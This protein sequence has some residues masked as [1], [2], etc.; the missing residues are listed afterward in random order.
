MRS[1][2]LTL[3]GEKQEAAK[4]RAAI[5]ECIAEI[6]RILKGM[7][8]KQTRIDKLGAHT[9]SLLAELKAMR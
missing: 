5:H 2:T 8:R 3:N 7:K 9:R 6:D 1:K 4:Y